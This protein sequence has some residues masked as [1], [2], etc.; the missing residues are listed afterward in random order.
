M[1]K[2]IALIFV[3]VTLFALNLSF[4]DDKSIDFESVVIV[5][6][7]S[8][9][10]IGEFVQNGSDYYYKLNKQEGT[11]TLKTLAPNCVKGLVYYVSNKY[12]LEYFKNKFN[13]YLSDSSLIE[14]RTVYYGYDSSFKDFNYI[15]GKKINVQLVNDGSQWIVG[16]PLILT[17]F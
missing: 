8:D 14:E 3:I 9:L 16:Y 17:G 13:F 1:K 11:K 12:N 7:N 6:T 5:S 10:D 2:M 4:S 15:N